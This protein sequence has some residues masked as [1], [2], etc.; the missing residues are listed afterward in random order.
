M[1]SVDADE[2]EDEDEMVR[3][4]RGERRGRSSEGGN[5]AARSRCD[6]CRRRRERRYV[7]S[8]EIE[9]ASDSETRSSV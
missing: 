3:C 2:D 6:S 7:S 8:L 5:T 1:L 9:D 4:S